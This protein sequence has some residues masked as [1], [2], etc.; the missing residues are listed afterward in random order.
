MPL[1]RVLKSCKEFF[2]RKDGASGI[3][4]AIIAAMV[5]VALTAFITPISTNVTGVMTKVENALKAPPASSS[6]GSN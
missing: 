2:Y 4:Y 3:E 1:S 6:G 5:A